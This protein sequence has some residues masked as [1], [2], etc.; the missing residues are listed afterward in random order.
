M[1][2][3]V[4]GRQELQLESDSGGSAHELY[5]IARSPCPAT[6]SIPHHPFR[7]FRYFLCP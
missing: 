7:V 3:Q 2:D 1:F 6:S 5:M 4:L